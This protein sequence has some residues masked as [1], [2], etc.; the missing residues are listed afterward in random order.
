MK[1]IFLLF[2]LCFC[3]FGCEQMQIANSIY[4][5]SIGFDYVNGNYIGYFYI[6]PTRDIA[7]NDSSDSTSTIG[8]IEGDSIAQLFDKIKVS[9]T[10]NVNF[11]HLKTM[12]FTNDFLKDDIC[13]NN[14]L[15]YISLSQGV[16]YNFYCFGTTDELSEVYSYTNP[17]E[18]SDLYSIIN[19]PN[20]LDYDYYGIDSV[21]FLNFANDFDNI[22]RVSLLPM[23]KQVEL[24]TASNEVYNTLDIVG[25]FNLY[26]DNIFYDEGIKYLSNYDRD[27]T[28]GETLSKLSNYSVSVK[29]IDDVFTFYITYE[30]LISN[31]SDV[32]SFIE[33]SI[34]S[35]LDNL[36]ITDGYIHYINTYNYQQKTDLSNINY[37]VIVQEKTANFY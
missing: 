37:N 8:K 33:N 19:T 29:V 5:S 10:S 1:K 16:S 12:I 13:I 14:L 30:K 34:V 11:N 28:V 27:V 25:Y 23:I 9:V 22:D 6:P 18:I 35:Y 17:T 2:M 24:Y 4:V 32:S 36:L 31:D 20:M 7:K 15:D 3:L 21:H 26:S